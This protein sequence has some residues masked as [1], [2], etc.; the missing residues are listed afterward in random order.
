M[1][2]HPGWIVT[3]ALAAITLSSCAKQVE[4]PM[5][6]GVC[7]HVVQLANG[8]MRF[9]KVSSGEPTIESC[10]A[11]LEAMRDRFLSIGG[12]HLDIT[13]AYQGNFLFLGEQGIF[14]SQDLNGPRYFLLGR[15]A[16]GRLATAAA[17]STG[18]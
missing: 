1:G 8:Q 4:A 2:L 11:S 6:R 17:L 12:S 16:D 15:T 10:A 3:A 9:N 7:W 18:Q 5:D 14:T 13:G